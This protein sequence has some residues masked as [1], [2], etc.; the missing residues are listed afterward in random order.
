VFQVT[1][2]MG[3]GFVDVESNHDQYINYK[4]N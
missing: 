3:L 4:L 2:K 1:G